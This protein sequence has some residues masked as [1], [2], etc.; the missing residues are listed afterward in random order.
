MRVIDGRWVLPTVLAATVA[1]AGT[2]GYLDWQGHRPVEEPGHAAFLCGLPTG[3][4]TPLGRLL[5]SGGQDVEEKRDGGFRTPVSCT[6]RVDGRVAVTVSA[7]FQ[8]GRPVLSPEA[9]EHPDARSFD[10]GT[11]AASWPGGATVSDYCKGGPVGHV[12]LIVTPGEA[13]RTGTDQQAD[14]E[15]IARERLPLSMK[16]ACG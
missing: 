13:V 1:G 6:V 9:A 2:V 3:D 7:A 8:D 14:L 12:Q 4:G 15:R 11:A 5:P 10:A 16:E